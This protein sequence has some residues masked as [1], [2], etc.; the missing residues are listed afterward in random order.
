MAQAADRVPPHCASAKRARGRDADLGS[1]TSTIRR[2][3]AIADQSA[4]APPTFFSRFELAEI[5]A[6]HDE[7][8]VAAGRGGYRYY[9]ERGYGLRTHTSRSID[10]SMPTAREL[11]EQADALMRRNRSGGVGD[12]GIPVL[13]DR[14]SEVRAEPSRRGPATRDRSGATLR[15]QAP[16]SR[17]PRADKSR[18]DRT[19]T[20]APRHTSATK[21]RRLSTLRPPTRQ[22]PPHPSLRY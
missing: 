10:P 1:T 11:L 5:L 20:A 9:R 17:T 4:P 6:G 16:D 2:P 15:V 21:A 12:S 19:S 8:E 18:D 7:A 3:A 22:L 13:T 14:V